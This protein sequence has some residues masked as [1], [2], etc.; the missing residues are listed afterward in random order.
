MGEVGL[1]GSPEFRSSL[2]AQAGI[3]M[4][5]LLMCAKA[6]GKILSIHS[7]GA[8][9]RVLELLALEPLAGTP[10]LHWFTGSK[11][12]L[13]I[14]RELDCWFSVGPAMLSSAAGRNAVAKMPR[15]RI[16]PETDGPF[17]TTRGNGLF[18]WQA[19]EIARPLAEMWNTTGD[20][21][22]VVLAQNFRELTK[23]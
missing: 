1:D 10:I 14:A 7:R 2:D 16:V 23:A 5:I 9:G 11:R 22:R 12:E 19:T 21:V 6:G 13:S 15:N 17:G 8:Q 20:D 18:P 4:D 3:F